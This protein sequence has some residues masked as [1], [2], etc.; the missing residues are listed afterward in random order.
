MHQNIPE[1]SYFSHTDTHS[2]HHYLILVRRTF[3]HFQHDIWVIIVWFNF[4]TCTDL[5]DLAHGIA[6]VRNFME[7]KD[8]TH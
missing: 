3:T 2:A 7:G 8:Q 1:A 4:Q 6:V 5:Q